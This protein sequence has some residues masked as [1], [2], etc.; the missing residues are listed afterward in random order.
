MQPLLIEGPDKGHTDNF[1]PVGLAG[2]MRGQTGRARITGN[3]GNQLTAV[4]A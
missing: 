4:W 2:G 3:D 1:A